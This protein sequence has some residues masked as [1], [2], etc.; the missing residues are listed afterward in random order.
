MK[1]IISLILITLSLLSLV[2][3]D[4]LRE[5][6]DHE[7][8]E[9]KTL[10]GIAPTCTDSGLTEGK[11]CR[12]CGEMLLLQEEI[13]PLGHI[14]VY[15][16]DGS[17]ENRTNKA[18][19]TREGCGIEKTATDKE[20]LIDEWRSASGIYY[21]D[22]N[23]VPKVFIKQVAL[24]NTP[25]LIINISNDDIYLFKQH[26]LYEVQFVDNYTCSFDHI[27]FGNDKKIING[28]KVSD[29]VEKIKECEGGYLLTTKSEHVYIDR[30]LVKKIG[31]Y[32]YFM[33]F[34]NRYEERVYHILYT[35]FKEGLE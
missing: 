5:S 25:Y 15:E 4:A 27:L 6:C 34:D 10:A 2:G 1:K 8:I 19:C 16:D 14:F 9:P 33:F 28:E 11:Q 31:N 20:R 32:Y 13:S 7:L 35:D 12:L 18:H 17:V 22:I 24:A 29:V 3:C 30:V 21:G 23:I 26:W